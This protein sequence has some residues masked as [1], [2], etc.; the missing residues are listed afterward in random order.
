VLSQKNGSPIDASLSRQPYVQGERLVR[1]EANA[2]TDVIETSLVQVTSIFQILL[3]KDW[4]AGAAVLRLVAPHLQKRSSATVLPIAVVCA[5][6][7]KPSRQSA[8]TPHDVHGV[9]SAPRQQQ[10]HCVYHVCFQHARAPISA[11]AHPDRVWYIPTL[12]ASEQH[13]HIPEEVP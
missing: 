8:A 12:S 7:S 10:K 5:A 11:P 13:Y 9:S 3:V 4:R 1:L 2:A 6:R